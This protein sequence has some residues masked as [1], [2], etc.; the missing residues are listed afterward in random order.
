M[1]N[2]LLMLAMHQEVQQKVVDELRDISNDD[3]DFNDEALG[4]MKYLEQV[5]KECLR[6]FPLPAISVR[7][8]SKDIQLG[9][10]HQSD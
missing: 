7:Y 4:K 5:I 3:E 9:E 10:R 2:V 6:L 1:S 8:A